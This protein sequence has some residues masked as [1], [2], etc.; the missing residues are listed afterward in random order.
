MAAQLVC[1]ERVRLAVYVFEES[2]M[3]AS[4]CERFG[5]FLGLE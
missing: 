5:L 2:N 3:P 1:P 4:R